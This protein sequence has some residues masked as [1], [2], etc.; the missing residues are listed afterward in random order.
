MGARGRLRQQMYWGYI[1]ISLEHIWGFAPD[2]ATSGVA[3]R[4]CVLR[5]RSYCAWLA[6]LTS[7]QPPTKSER[8]DV[9][10]SSTCL[11]AHG[12]GRRVAGGRWWAAGGSGGG[13]GG[14]GLDGAAAYGMWTSAGTRTPEVVPLAVKMTSLL[15]SILEK[16][17]STP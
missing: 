4:E 8:V 7:V 11:L 16:S 12:A 9:A 13:G 3:V 10:R 2:D 17:G 14:L 1:V 6:H 15:K 5:S